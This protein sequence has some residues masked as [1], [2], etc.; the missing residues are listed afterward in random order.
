MAPIKCF[1]E[2]SINDIILFF[3]CKE[4]SIHE[5]DQVSLIQFLFENTVLHFNAFSIYLCVVNVSFC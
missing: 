2:A 5:V 1:T 3:L 4:N